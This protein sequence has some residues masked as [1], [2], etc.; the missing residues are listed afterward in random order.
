MKQQ[1]LTLIAVSTT[2]TSPSWNSPVAEVDQAKWESQFVYR[3]LADVPVQVQDPL[4]DL[5]RS[6]N[7]LQDMQARLRFMM[8]EIRSMMKS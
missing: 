6:V 5:S 8:R 4:E 2:E 7:Q 3:E 1:E